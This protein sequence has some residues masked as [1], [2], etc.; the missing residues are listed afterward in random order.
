MRQRIRR[1]IGYLCAMAF[2]IVQIGFARF[3]VPGSFVGA[4]TKRLVC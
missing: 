1:L 4:V 3:F 2:F